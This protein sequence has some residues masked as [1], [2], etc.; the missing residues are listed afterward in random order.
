MATLTRPGR[1]RAHAPAKALP[2]GTLLPIS[3]LGADGT[4]VLEDGSFV[5]VIACY[6]RNLQTLT[7]DEREATFRSFRG[8]AAVQERGSRCS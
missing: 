6:P 5:R 7:E 4:I 2:V 8:V 1:R 3:R